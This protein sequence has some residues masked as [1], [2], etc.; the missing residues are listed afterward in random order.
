[1]VAPGSSGTARVVA[2][3]A[4]PGFEM[5]P[6]IGREEYKEAQK[7]DYRGV[8]GCIISTRPDLAFIVAHSVNCSS[9]SQLLDNPGLQHICAAKHVMRYLQATN[10]QTL[11]YKQDL[12]GLQLLGYTD[13]DWAVNLNTQKSTSGYCFYLHANSAAIRWSSK[14]QKSVAFS[15]AEAEYYSLS[16]AAQECCHLLN[17]MKDFGV[18]ADVP[19]IVRVDN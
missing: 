11:V 17:L 12:T 13:A 8:I 6:K 7:F 1:M 15:T 16:T 3:A 10:N 9:L 19:T 2:A 14:L 4:A 18:A 5:C